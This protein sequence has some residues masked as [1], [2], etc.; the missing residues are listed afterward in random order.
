MITNSHI[1]I[2]RKVAVIYE[3]EPPGSVNKEIFFTGADAKFK[4]ESDTSLTPANDIVTITGELN[5]YAVVE[6]IACTGL[7]TEGDEYFD[8]ITSIA[9]NF[10]TS[11]NLKIR[12]ID[13]NGGDCPY[14]E[15]IVSNKSALVKDVPFTRRYLELGVNIDSSKHVTMDLYV[16]IT[17]EDIIE[18]KDEEY[19]VFSIVEGKRLQEVVITRLAA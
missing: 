3:G 19:S 16:D 2:Y 1:N 18:Y 12:A 15:L 13:S 9:I 5:G 10:T 8:T 17:K 14:K 4:I 6:A 7:F 11:C